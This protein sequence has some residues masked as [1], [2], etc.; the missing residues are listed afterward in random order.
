MSESQPRGLA[1][2]SRRAKATIHHLSETS[3]GVLGRRT[4]ENSIAQI[5]YLRL[6]ASDLT[7]EAD[8]LT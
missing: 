2:P 5:V 7:F 8:T 4:V 6:E 1:S 3:I